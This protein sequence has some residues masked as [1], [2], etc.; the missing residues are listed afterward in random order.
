MRR[1]ALEAVDAAESVA[2]VDAAN[3]FIDRDDG[4]GG[5]DGGA[6]GRGL[7]AEVHCAVDGLHRQRGLQLL[8]LRLLV[9]FCDRFSAC[10]EGEVV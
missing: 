2:D 4:G 6:G 10:R 1:P 3:D 7:R 9:V 8:E 5:G